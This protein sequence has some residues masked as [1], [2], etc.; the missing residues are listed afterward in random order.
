MK[1]APPLYQFVDESGAFRVSDPERVFGLYFPLV[2]GDGLLSAITPSLQGDIKADQH[3]FL[4]LPMTLE[5]LH[6]SRSS[7]NFW[8]SLE[9]KQR[10]KRLWSVT[11]RSVWQRSQ[12]QNEEAVELEAGFLWHR[13]TRTN[14]DLG[15]KARVLNF[16]PARGGFFEIMMVEISNLS[17]T[18]LR[19]KATAA[20]P[21]FARSADNVR[22]H[23]HVTSL[24]NR[25]FKEP[26]GLR[27]CPTMSFNEKGHLVNTTSYFVLG[28][29]PKGEPPAGFFPTISSFIGEGGDLER[30]RAL[31]E[32]ETPRTEITPLDQGREAM[33]A[34]QFKPVSINP[35]ETVSFILLLG[36]DKGAAPQEAL[37]RAY[38]SREQV[39]AA[40]QETEDHWNGH[41]SSLVFQTGDPTF[42]KWIRWVEAQPTFR[43]IFG[44]SF[45]PDFDYGRGGRGWRDL[46]QD[47]LALL[48]ANPEEVRQDLL[49]NFAG[50]RIDGSNATIIHRKKVILPPEPTPISEVEEYGFNEPGRVAWKAEFVADRNNI[51]RTWMDHGIWPLLTTSLYLH[52]TGDWN[53]LLEKQPYFKDAQIWRGRK[54]DTAW[55]AQK[56]AST[57]TESCRLLVKGGPLYQGTVLEH[58]LVE[59]LVQFFNVGEH[60]IIRLEDADWNDGLDMAPERGESVAFTHLYAGNMAALADLLETLQQKAGWTEIV[61]AEEILLLLD[62]LRHR[63]NYDEVEQKK[64]RLEEFFKATS[65][66][67]SGKQASIPIASLIHDLRD[68]ANWIRNHLNETE[69]IE[70][71]DVSWFN[72]YYDDQGRRVEGK[73]SDG[74]TRMT[75]TGQVYPIMAK[76]ASEDRVERIIDAVDRFLWDKHLGGVRLNTDFGELQPWLGRAFSFAFGEKENGAVFSHMAVMYANALYQRGFA[77][78]GHRVLKSLYQMA[79]NTAR[80]RIYPG[81]PEYFNNE[82]R[83]RYMY[84]TGSASWYI[85]TLLT[86]VFGVRG[87]NGDLLLAPQLDPSHFD[88]KKEAR[89]ETWFAG[90][91]LK[92][93]FHNPSRADAAD[94]RI[95]SVQCA[96]GPVPFT[97]RSDREVLIQ[98]EIVAHHKMWEIHVHLALR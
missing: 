67:V 28:A 65:S 4:T 72:G 43:K 51:T 38:G 93:V 87:E 58:L 17:K 77:K 16:V 44:C 62:R 42:N 90:V 23:R 3:S 1:S 70:A 86:Q 60:N 5:D 14:K 59:T 47:C 11:G 63:V 41:L 88:R 21:L 53:F 98:R 82:G 57:D 48:L 13:V 54:Q 97:R 66:F 30:P 49:N 75:L 61:V 20:I 89:V 36:I 29:D 83:G 45:L 7:R 9:G 79:S 22:D 15:V 68:K 26:Y 27:V 25:I 35:S 92:I 52:Q 37:I 78:E 55:L 8:L 24:L 33:G 46:W 69:W 80:S 40:L 32:D 73:G 64:R 6:L 74:R 12:P 84:L 85:L 2:N 19:F 71:D 94:A 81:L 39:E 96:E 91:R 18:R 95:D 50:V 10:R 76:T 34:L 31:V 56:G